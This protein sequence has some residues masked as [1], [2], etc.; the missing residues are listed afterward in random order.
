MSNYYN[1]AYGPGV[2]SYKHV[3]RVNHP[4]A[5]FAHNPIGEGPFVPQVPIERLPSPKSEDYIRA[6]EQR[7]EDAD[8]RRDRTYSST[9]EH[10][11][12]RTES[13]RSKS[14]RSRSKS[15]HTSSRVP[16]PS[17]SAPPMPPMPIMPSMQPYAP[18]HH[19]STRGRTNHHDA[20]PLTMAFSTDQHQYIDSSAEQLSILQKP[21]ST[22]HYPKRNTVERRHYLDELLAD[23]TE[24]IELE[25]RSYTDTPAPELFKN[26]F[27]TSKKDKRRSRSVG[28]LRSAAQAVQSYGTPVVVSPQPRRAAAGYTQVEPNV[29]EGYHSQSTTPVYP[30]QTP[31][32]SSTHSIP[33]IRQREQLP[34]PAALNLA[35]TS[36]GCTGLGD[37]FSNVRIT[38]RDGGYAYGTHAPVAESYDY[39]RN[40]PRAPAPPQGVYTSLRHAQSTVDL[41]DKAERR[42][43]KEERK[44]AKEAYAAPAYA[45]VPEYTPAD[46]QHPLPPLNHSAA[47][48]FGVV[49]WEQGPYRE[50]EYASPQ[51]GNFVKRMFKKSSQY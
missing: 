19:S 27:Q 10:S 15:N 14:S 13:T 46:P 6:P 44:R 25:H 30:L 2:Q 47:Q 8:G 49:P 23:P 37:S 21:E 28:D 3:P 35:A 45:Y 1:T 11:R 7:R 48:R 50:A 51:K 22:S 36:N 29:V 32:L 31:F 33:K 16:Y 40:R 4:L 12:S 17:D 41:S 26:R 43:R 9:N 5:P 34:I 18:H 38:P 39:E 20:P 24:H 42:R